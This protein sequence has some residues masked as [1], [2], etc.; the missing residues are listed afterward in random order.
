MTAIPDSAIKFRFRLG[1]RRVPALLV[2][3]ILELAGEP[4]TH[5]DITQLRMIWIL[6]KIFRPNNFCPI[7]FHTTLLAADI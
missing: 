6:Y 5:L 7:P 4:F 2:T 1:M 3:L